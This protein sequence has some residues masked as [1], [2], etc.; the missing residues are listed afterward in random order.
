MVETIMSQVISNHTI[1][2][3]DIVGLEKVTDLIQESIIWAI[4]NPDLFSDDLLSPP[5]G[6]LLFGPPG[7]GKTMLGRAI[8]HEC[9][10]TFFNISASVL[11]SK[12]V[13]EGEKLVKTLF[14][15]AKDKAPSVIFIDEID[16]LFS[17]R[18]DKEEEHS[19]RM[20]TEFMVQTDGINSDDKKDNGHI[21]LIG[22]TNRPGEIDDALR[23]RLEKRI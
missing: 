19:R 16:S 18:S 8:A 13:G 12:W 5:K 10:A 23:R 11:T 1:S 2:F 17:M 4:T 15:I 3:N 7:N 21:L 6:L 14:E 20:K 22:A 9:N